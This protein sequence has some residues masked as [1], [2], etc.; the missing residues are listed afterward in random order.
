MTNWSQLP[1]KFQPPNFRVHSCH[2][3][4]IELSPE[5][6]PSELPFGFPEVVQHIRESASHVS[7][8]NEANLSTHINSEKFYNAGVYIADFAR[9]SRPFEEGGVRA[10]ECHIGPEDLHVYIVITRE[11]N[12]LAYSCFKDKEVS[13]MPI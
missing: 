4:G 5:F 1:E 11:G 3:R 7:F 9:S 2:H 6:D 10:F 12:R 8:L 13:R